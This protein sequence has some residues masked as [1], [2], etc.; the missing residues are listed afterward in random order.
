[1]AL[2][3]KTAAGFKMM[4]FA[5]VKVTYANVTQVRVAAASRSIKNRWT[6]IYMQFLLP[7]SGFEMLYSGES[8]WLS[9]Q[10]EFCTYILLLRG[11]TIFGDGDECMC[12]CT[13]LLL[14]DLILIVF[15]INY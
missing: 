12:V 8:A 14:P 1:M 3:I 4:N 10:L 15:C 11:M 5:K 13:H 6:R 2:E 9:R 7:K